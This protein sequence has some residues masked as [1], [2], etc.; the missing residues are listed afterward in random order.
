[1]K[2]L[3]IAFFVLCVFSVAFAQDVECV[4]AVQVAVESAL[5][6][7][8]DVG[9]NQLCY[10]SGTQEIAA[11]DELATPYVEVGDIV[12]TGVVDVLAI[13]ST[14]ESL[15]LALLHSR[16]NYVDNTVTMVAVGNVSLQ[17]LGNP[18]SDFVAAFV[19]VSRR[20][21][22]Q[23]FTQPDQPT[24]E[25]LVWGEVGQALG[26]SADGM[27]LLV[28]PYNHEPLWVRAV[29]MEAD[30]DFALLPI[31]EPDDIPGPPYVPSMQA[32]NLVS[33]IDD[34]PCSGAPESGL[35]VQAPDVQPS[36]LLVVNGLNISFD[37]TLFLQA[38]PDVG[39]V[40]SVLERT[41]LL[42]I[43]DDLTGFETGERIIVPFNGQT[44]DFYHSEREVY[45]YAAA[46]NLPSLYLLPR[47]FELPFSTGGLLTPY[48]EG[49]LASVT[50]DDPCTIAWTVDVNLRAG[51]GTDFPIRQGVEANYVAHPDARASGT[52][53]FLWWRLAPD[54]WLNAEN[55]IAAG[56]CGTLP[57][58]EVT[59]G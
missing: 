57:V 15:A 49:V 32:F 38:Q 45:H 56:T 42:G 29:D 39:M 37:G 34:A 25:Y 55:T 19:Q 59:N 14:E 8:R 44:V 50:A 7:C 11:R 23:V 13:S 58:L 27:W 33:G 17:N 48:I 31:V 43:N 10:A 24:D 20:N 51:P 47:A 21:G 36:A 4:D 6:S 54:I 30:Y 3:Q 26:R 9:A 18:R 41:A 40:I 35:L 28:I 5:A 2:S 1:L 52:D 46:R 12:E 16:A 22:A 53:G